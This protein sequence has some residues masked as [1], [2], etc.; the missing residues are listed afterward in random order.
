MSY[1]NNYSC[2]FLKYMIDFSTSNTI[3]ENTKYNLISSIVEIVQKEAPKVQCPQFLMRNK[4]S[5]TDEGTPRN[6]KISNSINLLD[7]N[8]SNSSAFSDG[9][10]PQSF[11]ESESLDSIL[12]DAPYHDSSEV[13]VTIENLV[14]I[15]KNK[16]SFIENLTPAQIKL[17]DILNNIWLETPYDLNNK[18]LLIFREFL[19]KVVF[20]FIPDI[21]ASQIIKIIKG[22]NS[23]QNLG[24]SDRTVER[25]IQ[26]RKKEKGSI[27]KKIMKDKIKFAI[28]ISYMKKFL[29]HNK[30]DTI[31]IISEIKAFPTD[32]FFLYYFYKFY[33]NYFDEIISNNEY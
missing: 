23:I 15:F 19:L 31:N 12:Q 7:P 22:V 10:F 25:W 32:K 9:T 33:S 13:K 11:I 30:S 20:K 14:E 1:N 27:N 8:L 5:L 24:C 17:L 16:D 28:N 2:E 29:L 21:K 6:V 26:E 4:R 18:D 3:S